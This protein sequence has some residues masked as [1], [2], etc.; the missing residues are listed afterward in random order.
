[1]IYRMY[2]RERN[3]DMENRGLSEAEAARLLKEHGRNELP[4]GKKHRLVSIIA[5]QFKDC[6]VIV[7][8]A[9]AVVSAFLGEFTEAFTVLGIV[10]ANAL[11]GTV[12]SWRTEKAVAALGAMTAPG[13]KVFRGGEVRSIPAAELVPGDLLVLSAGDRV[14]ADAE[15]LTANSL[16]CDE[17]M[18]T[19]ESLPAEKPSSGGMVFMGTMVVPIMRG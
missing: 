12:Q 14:G 11:L 9:A 7:L 4:S 6:M 17:S 3:A 1:M 2:V 15:I 19:G 10:L 13:A 18:L 8:I 16:A 5:G